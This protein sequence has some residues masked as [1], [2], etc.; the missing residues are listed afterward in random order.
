MFAGKLGFFGCLG[1]FEAHAPIAQ[2]KPV[3][4]LVSGNVPAGELGG[5]QREKQ[6]LL[7]MRRHPA[8]QIAA[9]RLAWISKRICPM[10]RL[11]RNELSLS[12]EGRG[13]FFPGRA[14]G[15]GDRA[16]AQGAEDSRA[17]TEAPDSC[18]E[19]RS[20]PV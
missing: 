11:G 12:G 3:F 14:L 2:T 15:Q 16:P 19:S 6:D 5:G 20:H 4:V 17:L 7:L 8:S 18:T 13:V 10:D 9:D 1:H